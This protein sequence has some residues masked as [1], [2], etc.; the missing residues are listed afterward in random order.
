MQ[1]SFSVWHW[2]IVVV[3]VLTLVVPAAAILRK[4][5]FSRWWAVLMLVPFLNGILVWVFAFITWPIERRA[6]M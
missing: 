6:P 3:Y 2:L 4:A 1:H 5:G